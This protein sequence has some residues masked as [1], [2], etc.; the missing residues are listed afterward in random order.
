MPKG[1]VIF[2]EEFRDRATYDGYVA[3]ALPTIS[4]RAV[5][6]SWSMTIPTYS[7]AIGTDRGPSCWSSPPSRLPGR[8][9]S[10]LHI[11]P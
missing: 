11:R 5:V 1:Y 10:R 3:K 2:T 6:R 8:G 9:T 4:R 7:K